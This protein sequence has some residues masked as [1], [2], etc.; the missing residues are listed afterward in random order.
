VTAALA[1]RRRG[2]AAIAGRW[3]AAQRRAWGVTARRL[4]DAAVGHD[5][6]VRQ[7]ELVSSSHRRLL[8]VPRGRNAK[9][10]ADVDDRASDERG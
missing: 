7:P 1:V 5:P 10:L 4:V 2:A 3:R 6:T 8:V 9:R